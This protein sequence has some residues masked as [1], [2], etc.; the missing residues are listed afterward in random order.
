M[1]KMLI[2]FLSVFALWAI[3]HEKEISPTCESGFQAT[4]ACLPAQLSFNLLSRKGVRSNDANQ[5]STQEGNPQKGF[6]PRPPP[7]DT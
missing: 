7:P 5:I 6:L 1:I 2:A 3:L 4:Y